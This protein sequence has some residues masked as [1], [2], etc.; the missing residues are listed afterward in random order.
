LSAEVWTRSDM[1]AQEPASMH[2]KYFDET[3]EDVLLYKHTTVHLGIY[4]PM[5]KRQETL[6]NAS[7][8]KQIRDSMRDMTDEMMLVRMIK[9]YEEVFTRSGQC[10]SD[11]KDSGI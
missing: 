5:R 1:A 2:M 10:V 4:N 9:H 8:I 6:D 7:L 3:F 11:R